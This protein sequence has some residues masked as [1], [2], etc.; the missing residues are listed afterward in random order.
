VTP[1]TRERTIPGRLVVLPMLVFAA[2]VISIAIYWLLSQPRGAP[3]PPP[4]I[5]ILPFSSADAQLGEKIALGVMEG[6][7]GIQGFTVIPREKAFP[8]KGSDAEAIGKKLNVRT[9]L[10]GS[11]EQNGDRVHVTARL[12][13][14]SDDYQFWSRNYDRGMGD[15]VVV[16][17]EI[18]L[19]AM[20]TLGLKH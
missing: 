15:L 20:E 5:V 7:S 10:D 19:A 17:T 16:E 18:A 1:T 6:L 4:S 3:P 14:T 12:I 2:T 9:V 11:V 8:E 13:N